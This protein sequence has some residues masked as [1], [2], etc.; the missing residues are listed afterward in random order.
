MFVFVVVCFSLKMF[1]KYANHH[2][3]LFLFTFFI[4]FAFEEYP[5]LNKRKGLGSLHYLLCR[6]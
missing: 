3:S 2:I 1:T 4:T 6:S 5:I